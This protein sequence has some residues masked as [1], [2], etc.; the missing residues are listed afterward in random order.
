MSKRVL[1]LEDDPPME[2]LLCRIVQE[3]GHQVQV[4]Q[5][6]NDFEQV[7]MG[8]LPDLML[9]D[10]AMPW[11]NGLDLNESLDESAMFKDIARV[12]VTGHA[13]DPYRLRAYAQ[14]CRA[15]IAKPFEIADLQETLREALAEADAPEE[16]TD[17]G[18]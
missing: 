4:A 8:E 9:I 17:A 3:E 6:W 15:F 13:E 2:Q 14:G 10:I 1:V 18:D 7:M 5:S 16:K 12:I 11:V